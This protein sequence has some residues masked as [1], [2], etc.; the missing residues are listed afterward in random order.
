M[1]IVC[2]DTLSKRADYRIFC[3]S[4]SNFP[5]KKGNFCPDFHHFSSILGRPKLIYVIFKNSVHTAKKT[6]H[7][8]IIKNNSFMPTNTKSRST[9][10]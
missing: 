6:Q 4:T 2:R 10:C 8:T 3:I 7:F 5:K 1:V 9:D